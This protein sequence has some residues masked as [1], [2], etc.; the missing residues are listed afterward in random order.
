M[1]VILE[2][3]VRPACLLHCFHQH[4]HR[5]ALGDAGT[6]SLVAD[7]AGLGSIGYHRSYQSS[8]ETRYRSFEMSFSCLH[9]VPQD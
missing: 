1:N 3:I 8:A 7:T 2:V 9:L 4:A 6:S 5:R